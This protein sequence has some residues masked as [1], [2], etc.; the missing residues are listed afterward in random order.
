MSISSLHHGDSFA[1]A[2]TPPSSPIQRAD[3]TSISPASCISI[4]VGRSPNAEPDIISRGESASGYKLHQSFHESFN[5]QVLVFI[6]SRADI[7]WVLSSNTREL[8]APP[9]LQCRL[10]NLPCDVKMPHC[11]RCI[12]DILKSHHEVECLHQRP[13]IPEERGSSRDGLSQSS[14]YVLFRLPTDDDCI[15]ATKQAL[16]IKVGSNSHSISSDSYSS[17]FRNYRRRMIGGTGFSQ[18]KMEPEVTL[19][20]S[21]VTKRWFQT[22]SSMKEEQDLNLRV[23]GCWERVW[24]REWSPS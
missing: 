8:M 20:A 23:N 17:F 15:W 4:S 19:I 11:Q 12:R 22:E 9:C 1:S 18:T 5:N 2:S 16:E 3:N 21:Q 13:Q 10:K 24:V 7:D 6:S 14:T